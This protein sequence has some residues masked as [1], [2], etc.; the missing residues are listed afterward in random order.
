MAQNTAELI[1]EKNTVKD[2]YPLTSPAD[3]KVQQARYAEF[4]NAFK[5]KF[6]TDKNPQITVRS[7]GR[8]N[9]IGEHIDYSHFAVLPMAVERDMVMGVSFGEAKG[10]GAETVRVRLANLDSKEFPDREIDLPKD[11]KKFVDIDA[12]VS[13]WAN[14]FKCGVV[15]AQEFLTASTAAGGAGIKIETMRPMDVLVCGNVPTGSG[16]SS[17]AAFVVCA[18]LAVLL[19]YGYKPTRK[20]LTE[21][22]IKCEQH[23]GVNS[24]GMDQA[25]SIYG[26]ADHALFVTFKPEL[27]ATPFSFAADKATGPAEANKKK[28][29]EFE[30]VIA[31]SLV[32]SNKHETAPT[33]YNLRVVEVTLA[34]LVLAQHLLKN[35]ECAI[36]DKKG[37]L[38][39]SDGNLQA[40]T[41]HNVLQLVY[42]SGDFGTDAATGFAQSIAML[43]HLET[44]AQD[45]LGAS[46]DCEAG[47][48]AATVARLLGVSEPEL[49]K[50]YM[51]TYP[52][53]F[54]FL[55]LRKRA[56]HVFSEAARVFE[57]LHTLTSPAACAT[58]SASALATA[59]VLGDLINQS[60]AS[61]VSLFQNSHPVVDRLCRVARAHGASGSRITGAGWG[62]ATVHLVKCS[63]TAKLVAGLKKEY[64][65]KEFP[66]ITDAEVDDALILSRPGN[67][68]TI[69]GKAVFEAL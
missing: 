45:V 3:L 48:S 18:T 27:T 13:D 40:G 19:G 25:A 43:K 26:V 44:L 32:V 24:G 61:A 2:V 46:E 41:L 42:P 66:G 7:P 10:N 68:T 20:Q 52:V 5:T 6:G 30:F 35:K 29:E 56:V 12:R 14:Y 47:H 21:L 57:F 23:V 63:Q 59:D 55:A 49:V 8:V 1:L 39:P 22:S 36:K 17:S 15:V 58:S 64:Y 4:A 11:A 34:A 67:G 28:E 9:L 62:G 54:K 69:L 31:N 50:R 16:L 53:S 37:P 65:E 38:L 33:N 51:T 60:H